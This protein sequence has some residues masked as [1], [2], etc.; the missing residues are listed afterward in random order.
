VCELLGNVGSSPTQT[1]YRNPEVLERV[2]AVV[3]QEALP[4]RPCLHLCPTIVRR[5]APIIEKWSIGLGFAAA[6]SQIL[7]ERES[8]LST[9]APCGKFGRT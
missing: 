1:D 6:V 8:E 9:I 4:Y 5:G 3:A 2:V 7:A